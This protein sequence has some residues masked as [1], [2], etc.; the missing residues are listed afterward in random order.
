M[1]GY[2]CNVF[3]KHGLSNLV[4]KGFD[5]NVLDSGLMCPIQFYCGQKYLQ[6]IILCYAKVYA[7]V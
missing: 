4:L 3:E 7:L 5:V 6:N 2:F 1:R